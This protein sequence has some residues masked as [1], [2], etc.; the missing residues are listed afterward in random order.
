MLGLFPFAL[1]LCISTTLAKL[2]NH[3]IDDSSP[4]VIYGHDAQILQ[5]N[6]S[7]C[8][9]GWTNQTLDG[10]STITSSSIIVPFTGSA[11]YVFLNAAGG[12]VFAIDNVHVGAWNNTP[13]P[14]GGIQLAYSNTSLPSERHVLVIAPGSA[15][16][17][18]EL[19][20]IIY[21][22]DVKEPRVGA[23]IG[24]VIGGIAVLGLGVFALLSLVRRRNQRRRILN[25]QR[26][27]VFL[28]SRGVPLGEG[29][30][31]KDKSSIKMVPREKS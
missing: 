8:A 11:V 12:C 19:D 27:K 28:N 18:M 4:D 16:A 20:Y 21:T 2:T 1:L 29:E 23:I 10:T 30:S 6:P 22:V 3:T 31:D 17:V 13:N 15:D 7:N 14:D 25:L 5:C 9:A 24:G 26:R